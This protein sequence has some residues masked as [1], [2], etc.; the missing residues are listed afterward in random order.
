MGAPWPLCCSLCFLD[1][2]NTPLLKSL[3]SYT[4]GFNPFSPFSPW[5]TASLLRFLLRNHLTDASSEPIYL[6]MMPTPA[7]LSCLNFL[8]RSCHIWPQVKIKNPW[9]WGFFY[10]E[11]ESGSVVSDSLQPHG[12]HSPWNSPGQNTGVG[13]LSLLQGIFPTQG[14]NP[15]LLHCGWILYQLSHQGSPGILEWVAYPFLQGIFPTQESNRGFLHFKW[16][17]YQLSYQG[18]PFSMSSCFYYGTVP[19]MAIE[20]MTAE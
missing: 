2:P 15:D 11:S 17:L 20:N 7:T 9:W 16:I 13:S 1:I 8:L 4:Q 6:K 10:V 14:L 18:S 12:L 3:V 5:L 19:G